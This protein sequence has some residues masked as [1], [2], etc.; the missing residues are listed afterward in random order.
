MVDVAILGAGI[1]GLTLAYELKDFCKVALIEK[2]S[3]TGGWIQTREKNGRIFEL[4]PNSIRMRGS[5]LHAYNLALKLG[6][7]KEIIYPSVEARKRYI[8]HKGSL[9]PL[10]DSLLSFFTSPLLKGI[11]RHLL[12][13]PFVKKS[14][15]EDESI[16]AFFSRRFTPRLTDTLIDALITGIY[17]GDGDALSMRS[18]FPQLFDAE[19]K[20]RSLL[21][22][23]LFKEKERPIHPFFSFQKGMETLTKALEKEVKEALHT[24]DEVQKIAYHNGWKITCVSG[25]TFHAR[26]LVSTLSIP[27]L[28]K[29]I[30]PLEIAIPYGSCAIVPL[31][32]KI[33][34]PG[35]GYLVP[36]KE[37]SPLLGAI[38]N[39]SIF[40]Q[41]ES[42]ITAMLGGGRNP[43]LLEKSDEEI[44][45]TAITEM[46]QHLGMKLQPEYGFV[47]RV[48]EAIP[49]YPVGTWKAIER[50]LTAQGAHIAF[51]GSAFAGV[52]VGDLVKHAQA[53]AHTMI[54]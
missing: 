4:G 20:S 43:G 47:H 31:V 46:S 32:A 8:L 35:F 24:E 23:M 25:K 44:M 33:P 3:R 11:R 49:H 36:H 21:L 9:E 13:E 50:F 27:A 26:F 29:L 7:E 54:K 48:Y 5:G 34:K 40:P 19:K 14:L 12:K 42:Q 28:K 17:A 22:W 38:F 10:P 53:L 45:G 6:L 15:L 52:S 18:C 37:K 1:S 51:T 41:R 2:S 30:S 39:G 16:N